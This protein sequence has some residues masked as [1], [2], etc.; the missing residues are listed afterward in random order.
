MEFKDYYEVLGVPRNASEKEIK[1]AFRKLA[2]QYH[3]DVRPGDKQAEEKFKE[4]NEANEVLSDPEKR[5]KYDALGADW[6]RYQQSG[7]RPEEYDFRRWSSGPGGGMHVEYATPE[8]LVDLFGDESPFSDF[9][10]TLFGGRP[11]GGQARARRGQDLEAPVLLSFD[12]AFRGA[13]RALDLDGRRIEARIPPGARTGSRVRLAGQAPSASG[14]QPGDI[15]L[16]VEVEPDPRFERRGDDLYTDAPVDFYTAAL[17]G[18]TRVPTPE[19]AVALKIPPRTQTGRT[20]RLKGKGMPI[21]GGKGRGDLFARTQIV[22]PENLS[23][24]EERALRD[25]AAQRGGGG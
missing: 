12:E 14:G 7:G 13:T 11:Q 10:S 19:G 1:A 5:N 24:E 21:P 8:D 2:R 18:E 25:L 20:F 16:V 6:Q 17:G 22:L 4:I 9:F 23:A 15:Y 3:P